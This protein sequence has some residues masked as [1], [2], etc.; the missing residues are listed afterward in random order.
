MRLARLSCAITY[1][2]ETHVSD[3]YYDEFQKQG[4]L[5]FLGRENLQPAS[6]DR[7]AREHIQPELHTPEYQHSKITTQQ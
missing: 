4:L 1:L 2:K 6:P 5:Q 7:I 3:P